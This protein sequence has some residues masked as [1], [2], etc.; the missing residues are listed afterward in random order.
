MSGRSEAFPKKK[1]GLIEANVT[2]KHSRLHR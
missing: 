2:A 1:S